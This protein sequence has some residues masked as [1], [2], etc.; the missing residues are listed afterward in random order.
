MRRNVVIFAREDCFHRQRNDYF[1]YTVS[2]VVLRRLRPEQEHRSSLTEHEVCPRYFGLCDLFGCKFVSPSNRCCSA[3]NYSDE[4]ERSPTNRGSTLSSC[5]PWFDSS[6]VHVP[7][8]ISLAWHRLSHVVFLSTAGLASPLLLLLLLCCY[9]WCCGRCFHSATTSGSTWRKSIPR[10]T[11]YPSCSC[12]T[13]EFCL[14]SK[15]FIS[16]HNWYGTAAT[17]VK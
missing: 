6:T 7:L 3:P 1:I 9:F 15:P 17:A 14:V 13:A 11:R 4:V 8:L 12:R 2:E 16:I 10:R 5:S